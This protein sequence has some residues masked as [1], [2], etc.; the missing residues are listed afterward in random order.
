M[1]WEGTGGIQMAQQGPV[2][3]CVIN[4]GSIKCKKLLDL[5]AP[6]PFLVMVLPTLKYFHWHNY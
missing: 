2:V 4:L 3:G 1:G 6:V 5:T